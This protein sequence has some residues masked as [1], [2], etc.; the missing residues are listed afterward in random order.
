MHDNL[1]H[2]KLRF[3]FFLIIAGFLIN[4]P[5]IYAKG[6]DDKNEIRFGKPLVEDLL[7]EYYPSDSNANA[8]ILSDIG[9]TTFLWNQFSGFQLHFARHLRIKILNKNGLKNADRR[10][11]LY[12]SHGSREAIASLKGYTYNLK[13]GKANKTKLEK[14][15]IFE[16]QLNDNWSVVSFALPNVRKGSVIDIYYEIQSDFLLN[17]KEWTF[18]HNIPTRFSQYTVTIPEYF[19]YKTLL[20]GYHPVSLVNKGK[21]S[22]NITITSKTHQDSSRL[23]SFRNYE[24]HKINFL[25]QSYTWEGHDIPSFR[26]EPYMDNINNYITALEFELAS[27]QYPE[28]LKKNLT[29]SW[30][31]IREKLLGNDYYGEF[32]KPNT[33]LGPEVALIRNTAHSHFDMMVNAYEYTKDKVKWNQKERLFAKNSLKKIPQEGSGNSADVNLFLVALLR[34]LDLDASPVILSTRKNGMLHPGQ[35]MLSKFNYVI[36]SVKIGDKL[37]LLDATELNC[38]YYMLP[39]RCINGKG[40]LI[41]ENGSEWVDLN[42]D[43]PY[44]Y[45]CLLNLKLDDGGVLVGNMQ[46]SRANY[47]ALDFR[48]EREHEPDEKQFIERFLGKHAGMQ[49]EKYTLTNM[50]SIYQPIKDSYE[51]TLK[52]RVD[53]LGDMIYL[54]P[55]LH[56][57]MQENPFKHEERKFPVDYIY[58]RHHKYLLNF[59]IPEDYVIDELPKSTRLALPNE[60]AEFLY[61]ITSNGKTIQLMTEFN[62]NRSVFTGL[63]YKGL[64]EFYDQVVAKQSEQIVLKKK[65]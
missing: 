54:N 34:A 37:Y 48:N 16:D 57:C 44:A 41:S 9:S 3:F 10:I 50:D 35:I 20:K 58:P 17:L 65:F 62:I 8:L 38:P 43:Q 33:L 22:G 27:Y 4:N 11:F 55:L 45:V 49:V 31:T 53:V 63:E 19:D 46:N 40:R 32:M 14:D 26:E 2:N 18:Q 30:E 25:Q 51:I 60:A 21:T 15:A 59:D 29:D 39:E 28:S 36:A 42:T 5:C 6:H 47:A 12:R 24:S 56:E 13:K 61:N 7:M 23:F 1:N 64:K 52:N